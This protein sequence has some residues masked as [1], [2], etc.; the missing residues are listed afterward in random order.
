MQRGNRFTLLEIV[1]CVAILGF[2]AVTVGWQITNM[3][4]DHQFSK[5]LDCLFT[6]LRKCQ[7]IATCDRTDIEVEIFKEDNHYAYRV[8]TDDP[9]P[10]FVS[11]TMKMTG[12]HKIEK[13]RRPIKKE[14]IHFYPS[15]RFDEQ[16]FEFFQNEEKKQILDL[17]KPSIIELKPIERIS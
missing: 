10:S 6:D 12:V 7:L 13:N 3:V 16:N 11:K 15:G 2:A 5:S 1:I 9:L 17:S 8:V 14:K 4:A